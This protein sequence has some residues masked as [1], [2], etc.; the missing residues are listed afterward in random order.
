MSHKWRKYCEP[1][2][3]EGDFLSLKSSVKEVVSCKKES[4]LVF[5][6]EQYDEKFVLLPESTDSFQRARDLILFRPLCP[7]EFRVWKQVDEKKKYFF[8]RAM[9]VDWSPPKGMQLMLYLK[10]GTSYTMNMPEDPRL[11]R[12]MLKTLRENIEEG[13]TTKEIDDILRTCSDKNKA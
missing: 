12:H 9:R 4:F 11:T 7:I 10:D 1:F 2:Q 5:T 8:V 13:D 3:N 6:L